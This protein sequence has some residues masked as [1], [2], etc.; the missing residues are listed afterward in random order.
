[1]KLAQKITLTV[2]IVLGA[3]LSLGGWLLIR[4]QFQR[5]LAA[6][7]E[8]A[9]LEQLR[10][11]YS[12]QTALL[13]Q[14]DLPPEKV[15]LQYG[16]SVTRNLGE[17]RHFALFTENGS[18]IYSA[19]PARI[20]YAWQQ[21]A[22]REPDSGT[23][24]QTTDGEWYYLAAN[25]AVAANG[26]AVYY[27]GA[28]D[29]TDVFSDRDAWLQ[30]YFLIEAAAF[31]AAALAIWLLVRR[32]TA[33]LARLETA[34]CQIA[35]GAWDQ[36]TGLRSRDEIGAL[37]RSFDAMA[38]AVEDKIRQQQLEVRRREDFVSA[39]THEI[40]TPMTSIL[41]YAGLLRAGIADPE[42][43]E[44]AAGYIVHEARRLET[45]SQ[46]LLGLMCL[47]REAPPALEPAPLAAVLTAVRR[48]QPPD[49]PLPLKIQVLQPAP[50]GSAAPAEGS[51][52]LRGDVGLLCD[53]LDNL[54]HNARKAEP[55]DHCVHLDLLIQTDVIRFTVWDTGCGIPAQ[56]LPRLT[57]P[58]Y[59]VDKS[60]A[61]AQNGSGIGL[62]LAQ[63]I[64]RLHGTTL[65]FES[66]VGTGTRVHF[67]I[68][69]I[70]EKDAAAKEGVL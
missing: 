49:T 70:P 68:P 47:T 13:A 61:R 18:L 26:T 29:L 36:R 40:R 24:R 1:M 53:L 46:K 56:E 67:A 55:K 23:L 48:S 51:V 69:R 64:A 58:F 41:G 43:R 65:E 42:A 60:R 2:W 32:M 10:E 25:R 8:Q 66:A 38:A 50:T 37:S 63:Q 11:Q 20:P 34:S 14:S 39:F 6:G 45:L 35:A 54:I 17:S 27:V 22:L 7:C 16:G 28:Y 4:S 62:A 30:S 19:I 31:C 3:V 12:L 44:Q 21:Q 52:F 33:P 9:A 5:S 59:M 57:E 15:L